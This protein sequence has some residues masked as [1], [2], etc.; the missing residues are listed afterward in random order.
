MR[1]RALV[2]GMNQVFRP[3]ETLGSRGSN[4]FDEVKSSRS[5]KRDLIHLQERI[6]LTKKDIECTYRGSSIRVVEDQIKATRKKLEAAYEEI[7]SL[8]TEAEGQIAAIGRVRTRPILEDLQNELSVQK[9]AQAELRRTNTDL[10]HQL[11]VKQRICAQ[12]EEQL[13]RTLGKKRS[14]STVVN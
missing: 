14:E 4:V 13:S 12:L 2:D 8:E 7:S 10:E 3:A 6:E 11:R 5:L 9:R 1:L